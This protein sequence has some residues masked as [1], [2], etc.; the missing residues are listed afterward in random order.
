MPINCKTFLNRPKNSYSPLGCKPIVVTT[1]ILRGTGAQNKQELFF[2][3]KP[4]TIREHATID[5]L[6]IPPSFVVQANLPI[7]EFVRVTSQ[8]ETRV[9]DT[10]LIRV[11]EK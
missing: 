11:T 4:N 10:G 9:I 1:R 7:T 2:L 8:A 3:T 6:Y 5:L